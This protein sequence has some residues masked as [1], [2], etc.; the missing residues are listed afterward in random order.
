MPDLF[1]SARAVLRRA[2]HHIA[3]FGVAMKRFRT[4]KS[5]VVL[6]EYDLGFGAHVLKARFAEALVEDLA[7]IMFDAINNLR[8]CLDHMTNAIAMRHRG[9]GKN[10]APFPFAKDLAHWP[11]KIYGLKNDIPSE[12]CSL[13]DFFQPYKGGDNTLWALNYIANIKKHAR[14]VPVG[15]GVGAILSFPNGTPAQGQWLST[16]AH[17][18]RKDEIVIMSLPEG[19]AVPEINLSPSVVLND[20]EEIID[21]KQPIAILYCTRDRVSSVLKETS[22]LCTAMGWV[23]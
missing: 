1:A 17:L 4:E 15:F 6:V 12:V 14:L 8:A 22:N 2:E 18:H 13:F 19:H 3:D 7:C 23:T 9:T 10:F 20:A 11:N 5:Y 21:G 16:P